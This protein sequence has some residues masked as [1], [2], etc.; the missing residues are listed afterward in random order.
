MD[1]AAQHSHL[2]SHGRPLVVGVMGGA[3]NPIHL[4]HVLLAV[5]V[6]E[7]TPVDEVVVV[8][9]FKHPVKA[10]LLPFEDRVEMCRLAVLGTGV[11]VSTVEQRIGESNVAML[12]AVKAEYPPGT[13]LVWICGDDVFDWIDNP[14]G[15]AMLREV[16]GLIVQ[17]RLCRAGDT[18]DTFDKSPADSGRIED[19][20]QR[21]GIKVDIIF[22]KLPHLSSSLVRSSPAIWRAYLPQ[23]VAFYLDARPQLLARLVEECGEGPVEAWVIRPN[24]VGIIE[25]CNG[26]EVTQTN[27][28]RSV[29][30]RCHQ[31]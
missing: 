17:R 13:Q 14:K 22:G 10:D 4:G 20:R 8:P 21:H 11:Q 12:R 16:D 27:S 23:L 28:S 5:T 30:I 15:Q 25:D 26:D 6:R 18:E 19:I 2:C 7:T 1:M 9:V 3:F 31:G 29:I 24:A